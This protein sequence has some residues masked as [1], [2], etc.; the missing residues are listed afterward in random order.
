MTLITIYYDRDSTL[1]V[2]L[3]E[4]TPVFAMHH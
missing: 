1:S 2:L 4:I 3:M